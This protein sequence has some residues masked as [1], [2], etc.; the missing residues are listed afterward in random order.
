MRI[1][2]APRTPSVAPWPVDEH[3]IAVSRAIVIEKSDIR[4]PM[5]AI[6]PACRRRATARAGVAAE[7]PGHHQSS[8][9]SPAGLPSV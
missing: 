7:L 5:P 4:A 3:P 8:F 6:P 2:C 1:P 9:M